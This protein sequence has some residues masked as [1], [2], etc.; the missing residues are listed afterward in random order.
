[1]DDPFLTPSIFASCSELDFTLCSPCL[2]F[3]QRFVTENT[4]LNS[5]IEKYL[6]QE[7]REA[8]IP[9]ARAGNRLE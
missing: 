3:R 9:I 4:C 2:L 7:D 1:M 6:A 8:L 5:L